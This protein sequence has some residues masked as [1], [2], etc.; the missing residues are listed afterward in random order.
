MLLEVISPA[1]VMLDGHELLYQ[2]N[3]F[4]NLI[5]QFHASNK[6]KEKETHP[7]GPKHRELPNQKNDQKERYR[8]PE[9]HHPQNRNNT[10]F[11]HNTTSERER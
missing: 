3:R 6:K 8:E 2:S 1:G 4:I 9:L 11:H 7:R 10:E 5:N